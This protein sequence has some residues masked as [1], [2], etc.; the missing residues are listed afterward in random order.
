VQ[1]HRQWRDE[2]DSALN[3]VMRQHLGADPRLLP[4]VTETFRRICSSI[5]TSR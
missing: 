4:V 1:S 2:D 3:P 5:S